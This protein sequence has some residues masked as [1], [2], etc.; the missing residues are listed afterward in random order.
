MER[1]LLED[2]EKMLITKYHAK[3]LQEYEK[4]IVYQINET[5]ILDTLFNSEE[6]QYF[7]K[8]KKQLLEVYGE[9]PFDE[10]I[11][12]G[13][14]IKIKFNFDNYGIIKNFEMSPKCDYL[15]N[16]LIII[17]GVKEEDWVNKAGKYK[18]YVAAKKYIEQVNLQTKEI[19]D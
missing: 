6:K 4:S 2:L 9:I 18:R 15:F 1:I 5:I 16:D 8:R 13:K 12:I 3:K 10:N 17:I 19:D 14:I 7:Q 11:N